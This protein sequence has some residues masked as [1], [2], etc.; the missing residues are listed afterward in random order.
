MQWRESIVGKESGFAFTL[1]FYR[2][3]NKVQP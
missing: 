1:A 2:A 3:L